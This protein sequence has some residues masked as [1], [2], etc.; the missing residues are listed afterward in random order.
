MAS[1]LN[2]VTVIGTDETYRRQGRH[3]ILAQIESLV[4]LGYPFDPSIW[5]AGTA[6]YTWGYVQRFFTRSPMARHNQ[7]P[8]HYYTEFIDDDYATFVGCPQTNTSW[9]LQL[10]VAKGALPISLLDAVLVVL[11]ENFGMENPDQRL[12]R[13]LSHTLL[14]PIMRAQDIPQ[15]N[16]VLFESI[17]NRDVVTDV[18]WPFRFREPKFMDPVILNMFLKNY[19]KK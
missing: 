9:F 13:V 11:Q 18:N 4:P 16:V 6:D 2:E 8:M 7:L 10:A 1:A 17:A 12:W 14:T 5:G 19:A 3:I 15:Q